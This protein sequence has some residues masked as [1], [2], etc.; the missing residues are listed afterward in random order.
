MDPALL[1]RQ[2]KPWGAEKKLMDGSFWTSEWLTASQKYCFNSAGNPCQHGD[3]VATWRARDESFNAEDFSQATGSLQPIYRTDGKFPY[4][5]FD[6]TDDYMRCGSG[7]DS[8]TTGALILV[9]RML[10]ST[11]KAILSSSDEGAAGRTWAV[12]DVGATPAIHIRKDENQATDDRWIY[13]DSRAAQ[14]N[15]PAIYTLKDDGSAWVGMIGDV[16]TAMSAFTG[17][18]SGSQMWGSVT[19]RDNWVLGAIVQNAGANSWCNFD[20][21]EAIWM[22]TI[23]AERLAMVYRYLREKYRYRTIAHLG[24]SWAADTGYGIELRDALKDDWILCVDHGVGSETMTQIGTRFDSDI[25][26]K[27]Y[28]L[29]IVE[30]A[31]NDLKAVS[32]GGHTAV[33]NEFKRICDGVLADGSKLVACNCGPFGNNNQWSQTRQTELQAYNTLVYNYCQA[34]GLPLID[35]YDFA[36][37]K[38]LA[39]QSG[40]VNSSL[41]GQ[42]YAFRPDYELSGGLHFNPA[43]DAA[44]ARFIAGVVKAQLN[45]GS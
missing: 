30:G 36:R 28:D 45:N 13:I 20:L 35:L 16:N 18:N 40:V 9:A 15:V 10:G 24:D 25:D 21:F 39:V 3:G 4:V 5:R 33:F 37:N 43:G 32:A 8:S 41:A 2:V 42:A 31:I 19:L 26:G 27:G 38:D 11:T 6:G 17:N 23:T 1:V 34:K 29:V 44:V 14:R 12:L 22:T 7:L